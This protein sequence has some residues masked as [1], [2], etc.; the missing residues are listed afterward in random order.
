MA[1]WTSNELQNKLQTNPPGLT[2]YKEDI[3]F[4]EEIPKRLNIEC[5]ICLTVILDSPSKAS[6]CGQ[7]FCGPCIERV[8]TCP[9]C[10]ASGNNFKVFKDTKF[11]RE[12]GSLKVYCVMNWNS[13]DSCDWS[14]ELRHL[15]KH[16]ADSCPYIEVQCPN[17]GCSKSG[18]LRCDL[19]EHLEKYCPMRPYKCRHCDFQETHKFIT[20]THYNI[21]PR[22][23]VRCPLKCAKGKT[24]PRNEVEDHIKRDCPLQPV[25]CVYSWLGCVEKPIRKNLDSHCSEEHKYILSDICGELFDRSQK[26]AD[27]LNVNENHLH[28]YRTEQGRLEARVSQLEKKVTLLEQRQ[29]TEENSQKERTRQ[30]E[31]NVTAMNRE[32]QQKITAMD[33]ELQ[34]KITA[35]DRERA[36]LQFSYDKLKFDSSMIKIVLLVLII[37][38]VI[39]VLVVLLSHAFLVLIVV[40]VL[41]IYYYH[42]DLI[43]LFVLLHIYNS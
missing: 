24:L 1:C 10:R 36:N 30:L 37:V 43:F 32:I 21:C 8:T 6:C 15:R 33:R 4:K 13:D 18:L 2:F 5:P 7:Q 29:K 41:F 31:Q 9:Q 34:Q 17:R 25:E 42:K 28:Q 26:M 40:V 39:L 3:E 22:F 27:G 16:L 12:V 38:L 11:A 20:E 23:P 35:M 19:K 14:G